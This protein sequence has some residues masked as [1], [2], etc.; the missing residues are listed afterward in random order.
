[1][2]LNVTRRHQILV[3][4]IKTEIVNWSRYLAFLKGSLRD[5]VHKISIL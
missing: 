5:T 4:L 1:M 3:V 2:S